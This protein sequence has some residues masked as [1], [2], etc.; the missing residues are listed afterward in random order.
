MCTKYQEA[1]KIVNL[2]LEGLVAQTVVGAKVLDLCKFGTTVMETA[3]SKLYT[4]K[5]NGKTIDRGVAF[6]VCVSVNDVVCNC[7]PLNET[8][9]ESTVSCQYRIDNTIHQLVVFGLILR[10]RAHYFPI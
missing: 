8:D 4:K 5:V 10:M 3:A 7:S 1:S 2:T 9:P 6:P